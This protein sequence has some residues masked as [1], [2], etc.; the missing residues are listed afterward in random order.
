MHVIAG[1]AVALRIAADRGLPRA[2][3]PHGRRRARRSPSELLGAG[4]RRQRAD[5]RHRRAPRARRP[6]RVR[7]RRPA[8]RGPPARR[9]A[10]PST[11]TP[12]PFDPRPPMVTSGLRVGT[13]ALAT[14]GLQARRLRARSADH[15]HRAH[16][17]LRGPARRA[18]RARTRDRRALPAVRAPRRRRAGLERGPRRGAPGA[19]RPCPLPCVGCRSHAT[20]L[21]AVCAFLVAAALPR[22]SRRSPRA[23]PARLGAV[24]RAARPRACTTA[25]TPLLGGLAILAGVL[26]AG[27]LFL[28]ARPATDAA[29]SL[30][31]R[32]G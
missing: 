28:P 25:T 26:V 31:G 10:S 2:P 23:S 15:R 20:E 18:G 32:G 29:G 16:A 1:K 3:A 22:C 12:C 17:G 4:R 13:P 24:D 7:A 6:A 9:S 5:R 19:R 14:R 8:G 11:A 27:V 30:A 21:D